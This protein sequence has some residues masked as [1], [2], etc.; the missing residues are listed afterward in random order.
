MRI[1][2]TGD[3]SKTLFSE[4]YQQ[5]YHST[6]GALTESRTV[7]L[8]GSRLASYLHSNKEQRQPVR[9]LEIGFGLGLNFL[10][11]ADLALQLQAS[12][13]YIAMENDPVN[14][15]LVEQLNYHAHLHN[16]ELAGALWQHLKQPA[17]KAAQTN[18]NTETLAADI[19]LQ[20]DASLA[21]Q[22]LNKFQPFNVI[23]L[24]AFS[25]DSNPEC[26]RPEILAALYNLTA[27]NG[28]LVTY[29]SK[30]AVRRG[31]QHA[32]FKIEK[33]PGPP[34]KREFLRAT[35]ERF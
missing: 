20:V 21:F 35:R 16:P 6:H 18:D 28:T 13:D 32:G 14:A 10:L 33:L 1:V 34:G 31:L 25:P 7:F 24:D 30:G 2:T 15:E 22:Q 27:V 8:E 26:W 3:G 19:S 4:R 11:S 23:Y 5:T 29:S 12:L 17:K 9:I